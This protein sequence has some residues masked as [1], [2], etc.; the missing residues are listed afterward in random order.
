MTGLLSGMLLLQLTMCTVASILLLQPFP[1]YRA[2]PPSKIV[3]RFTL[4]NHPFIADPALPQFLS[5]TSEKFD[6]T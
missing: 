5:K 4:I 6:I 1:I 3:A 2:I